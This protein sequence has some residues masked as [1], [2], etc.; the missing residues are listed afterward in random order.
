MA[1][2]SGI[3]GQE[4][5]MPGPAFLPWNTWEPQFA[6]P[7]PDPNSGVMGHHCGAQDPYRVSV[8][9][10]HVYGGEEEEVDLV[11]EGQLSLQ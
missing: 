3:L 10:I 4:F 5:H 7:A 2:A 8:C 9:L 11:R 1:A 6:W